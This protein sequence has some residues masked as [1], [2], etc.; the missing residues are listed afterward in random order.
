VPQVR[1]AAQVRA[2]FLYIQ[3]RNTHSSGANLGSIILRRRQPQIVR[4]QGHTIRTFYV[5]HFGNSPQGSSTLP[6]ISFPRP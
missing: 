1:P 5:F 2:R 3:P 4:H 6:L